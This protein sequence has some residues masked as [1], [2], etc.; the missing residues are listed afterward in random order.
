MDR[1]DARKS[2][3]KALKEN[4]QLTKIENNKMFVPTGE[5]TGEVIEPLLTKQWFLDSKKLCNQVL[6]SIKKRNYIS[7]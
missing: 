3:I 5:R 6:K 1:Y 2:I 7:S 4:G